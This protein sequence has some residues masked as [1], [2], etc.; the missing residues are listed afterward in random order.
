MPDFE[1]VVDQHESWLALN[2]VQGCPKACTY[3]FLKDRGLTRARPTELASPSHAAAL[4]LASPYH[5][6]GA[7]V[8]LYT[9]TDALATPRTR[10]HLTQLLDA[11]ADRQVTNP[12]VLITKCRITDD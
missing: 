6:P 2:P 12:L 10:R 5:H 4:L 1:P 8:A 9:C 11:L 3:C 7:A